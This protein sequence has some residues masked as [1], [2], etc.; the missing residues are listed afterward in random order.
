LSTLLQPPLTG[1]E[2]SDYYEKNL[3]KALAF[4]TNEKE[5]DIHDPRLLFSLLIDYYIPHI[6]LTYFHILNKHSMEWL[7]KFENDCQFIAVNVKIDRLT[8]TGIG[9]EFFGSKML[10]IDNICDVKQEGYKSFYTACMCSIENLFADKNEMWIPLQIYST[11][12]LPL[13]C[14]EK[15]EKYT[16]IENEF[17]I[18]AYDCPRI[19]NG[20]I[21]QKSK[22]VTLTGKSGIKYRGELCAGKDTEFSCNCYALKN[23]SKLLSHV[24]AEER[25]EISLDSQFKPINIA[26]ISDDCIFIGGKAD[27]ARYINKTL[28]NMP[29]DIYVNRTVLR[30]YNKYDISDVRESSPKK[31]VNCS[32]LK[33]ILSCRLLGHLFDDLFM[34]VVV[35]KHI[36]HTAACAPFI[37]LIDQD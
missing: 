7:D 20:I 10:Y 34:I 24:I 23:T 36:E 37:M 33:M 19:Q 28:K 13:L 18:I 5:T 14:R 25:G 9:K 32:Q 12:S 17:R 26:D 30:N 11:L 21:K 16:D 27:C 6:Y 2:Y 22:E 29:P 15:S 1:Y 8:Q 35:G 4:F 3:V 31:C